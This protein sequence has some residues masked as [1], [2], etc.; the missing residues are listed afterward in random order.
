MQM[1][2]LEMQQKEE[3]LIK[4]N[5]S[6]AIKKIVILLLVVAIIGG[7]YVFW[8]NTSLKWHEETEDAYVNSHQNIVTSQFTKQCIWWAYQRLL[9][10]KKLPEPSIAGS[11]RMRLWP[12][13]CHIQ[14]H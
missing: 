2:E 11:M 3:E 10:G 4:G 12:N 7:L 5:S 6:R 13:G 9:A 14:T 8:W 1:Q